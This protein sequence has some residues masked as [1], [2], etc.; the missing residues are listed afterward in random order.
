MMYMIIS[1][2]CKD[3]MIDMLIVDTFVEKTNK[4]TNHHILHKFCHECSLPKPIKR[5]AETVF[6]LP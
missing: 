3:C 6:S 4:Q 2:N 1:Y 5:R